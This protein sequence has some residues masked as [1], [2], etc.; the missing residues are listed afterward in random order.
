MDERSRRSVLGGTVAATMAGL[1]GC[2]GTLVDDD[3]DAPEGQSDDDEQQSAAGEVDSHDE[4][5]IE[6]EL[7]ETPRT[8]DQ[9]AFDD[10]PD[11]ILESGGDELV[12]TAVLA[13]NTPCHEIDEYDWT[14]DEADEAVEIDVTKADASDSDQQCSQVIDERPVTFHVAD[15][16]EVVTTIRI[17]DERVERS[18]AE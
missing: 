9:E 13:F 3:D 1:A 4:A 2:L 6:V 10:G 17:E 14:Y 7:A 12:V 5:D 15:P 8:T 16:G 11:L 18:E